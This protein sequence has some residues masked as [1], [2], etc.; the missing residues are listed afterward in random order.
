MYVLL[1]PLASNA[2]QAHMAVCIRLG[3]SISSK[4]RPGLSSLSP[5][6]LLRRGCPTQPGLEKS[7][8]DRSCINLGLIVARAHYE[9]RYTYAHPKGVNHT[10]RA[11]ADAFRASTNDELA[12]AST[13]LT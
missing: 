9:V 2:K 8:K 5:P 10:S 1:R 11:L 13:A 3:I 4:G 6:Y 12:L 7:N